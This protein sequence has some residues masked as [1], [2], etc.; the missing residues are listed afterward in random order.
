MRRLL[1]IRGVFVHSSR[2]NRLNDINLS[3]SS[4]ER[5]AL[6]GS[7]GSGK[8]SL[9]A[10][11]NGT[12]IPDS[13]KVIWQDY[14]TSNLGQRQ[15]QKIGTLW[16]DLRLV[17]ELNVAQNINCGAL[18][19]RNLLWALANLLKPIELN[20]CSECLKKVGLSTS[21]LSAMVSELSG[22]QRQRVAIARLLRQ[23]P[24]LILADE[25]LFSLDPI[26]AEE[27][28]HL[29]LDN[30]MTSDMGEERTLLMSL[31]QPSFFR[32]FDR[33]IALKSGRV[34]FDQPAECLD[35]EALALIYGSA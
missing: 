31:H 9:L 23:K 27:I 32:H 26:L 34:V 13:G 35:E 3:I 1:E 30:T 10:V 11:A 14:S 22:G 17:E 7:N 5:V 8:S 2:G 28:L 29:F 33:V 25:P 24:E 18:A 15:R 6:V 20:A 12:L 4:G 21:I 19:N 16:Q